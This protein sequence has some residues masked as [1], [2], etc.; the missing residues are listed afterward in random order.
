[1]L[2][3][4]KR[5]AE[6]WGRS[7]LLACPCVSRSLAD[8]VQGRHKD[9]SERN[10]GLAGFSVLNTS[11]S[12]QW[13]REMAIGRPGGRL[14]ERRKLPGES[15]VLASG[16]LQLLGPACSAGKGCH[17]VLQQQEG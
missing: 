15:G 9:G 7:T 1:M 14:V 5:L 6:R 12:G 11:G 16:L 10:A 13:G 4:R 2:E 17:G 3:R 8:S